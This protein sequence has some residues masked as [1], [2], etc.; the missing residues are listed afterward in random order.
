MFP[1]FQ[2]QAFSFEPKVKTKNPP[3]KRN[4]DKRPRRL[5]TYHRATPIGSRHTKRERIPFRVMEPNGEIPVMAGTLILLPPG[6]HMPANTPPGKNAFFITRD[7]MAIAVKAYRSSHRGDEHPSRWAI[8][9]MAIIGV[10]S[11]YFA[12]LRSEEGSKP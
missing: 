5:I 3:A 4:A 9:S 11:R 2:E 7:R 6:A 1:H 12:S 10:I 8:S